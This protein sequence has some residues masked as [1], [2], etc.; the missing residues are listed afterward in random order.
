MPGAAEATQALHDAGHELV[1]VTALDPIY[2]QARLRN[3][4]QHG[5][6]IERVIAVPH[7]GVAG[8]PKAAVIN[9]LAPAAF[10]D[11]FLP[12]LVG[13]SSDVHTAL[14]RSHATGSPNHGRDLDAVRSIH[15]DLADFA[16]W[17]LRNH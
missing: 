13:L 8:N 14:L 9:Q 11:D 2:E 4:R 15:Y 7:A 12:Y 5:F 10:V 3:L 6:P 1:C 17:W 16:R